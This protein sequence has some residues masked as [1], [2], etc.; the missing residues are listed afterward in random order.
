MRSPDRL[1]RPLGLFV[2]SAC[3][4]FGTITAC[5]SGED[6][7]A[8]AQESE[9]QPAGDTTS[10][11][12]PTS[13]PVDEMASPETTQE[14]SAEGELFPDVI[15][16]VAH[17]DG[18]GTWTFD[19]TLSSPYDSPD[20]YADAWR[21]V[22]P[23]GTVYGVRELSHD[24]ASEQPFTRSLSRIEIPEDVSTVTVEG[25]DQI[26]GWGGGSVTVDL[27]R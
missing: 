5:G 12:V 1:A 16:A 14:P 11:A 19:A 20:R 6:E 18:D 27:D 21:V 7:G 17:L 13:A 2:V 15:G 25:R 23:D 4:A 26:S 10:T 3:L 9:N 24:H 8:V 22:G